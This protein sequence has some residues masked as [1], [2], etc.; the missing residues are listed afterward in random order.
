MP[1]KKFS[2][3][4]SSTSAIIQQQLED[5]TFHRLDYTTS[6]PDDHPIYA[7]VGRVA[8]AWALL[9]HTLDEIIW[10]LSGMD[11]VDGAC[12]TA[13]MMGTTPRYSA[14]IAQLTLRKDSEPEFEKHLARTQALLNKTYEPQEKR[15][16]ILHDVWLADM[17][18]DSTAQFRA[19]PRKQLVYG[20]RDVDLKDI[21]STI[22][23]IQKLTASVY[24][25]D[26]DIRADI[27]ASLRKRQLPQP[28]SPL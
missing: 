17:A 2:S 1:E 7:L 23:D 25:L 14:I 4:V 15:N 9:E 20:I 28:S 8:A 11:R 19:W 6:P 12:L 18:S 13:Q 22:E 24:A 21:L 16:R 27:G 26:L 10:A 5:G 3:V